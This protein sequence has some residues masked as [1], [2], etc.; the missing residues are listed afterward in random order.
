MSTFSR[1]AWIDVAED[2]LRGGHLHDD[3]WVEILMLL[4]DNLPTKFNDEVLRELERREGRS[5]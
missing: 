3:E 2:R 5:L 1:A 4:W